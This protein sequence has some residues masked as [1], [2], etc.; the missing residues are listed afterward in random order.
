MIKLS[1][2]I[3]SHNNTIKPIVELPLFLMVTLKIVHRRAIKF[4]TLSFTCRN[5]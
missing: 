5:P 4:K 1:K 2:N 3:F